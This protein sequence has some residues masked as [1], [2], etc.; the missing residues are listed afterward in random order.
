MSFFE[1]NP[2]GFSVVVTLTLVSLFNCERNF[3]P[4]SP[5]VLKLTPEICAHLIGISFVALL[6]FPIATS[7]L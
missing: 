5:I 4:A 2:I 3:T 6:A 1:S 7:I